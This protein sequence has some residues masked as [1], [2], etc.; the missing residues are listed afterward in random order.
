MSSTEILSQF[1]RN[2]L[3]GE[4]VPDDLKILL[5]HRDELAE[6]TGIRLEW[7]EGWAPWLDTSHLSEADRR[8][9]DTMA[10]IR[11][12]EEVCGHIAFVAAAEDEEITSATMR[13]R[14]G[15]GV[16]DSLLVFFE[17]R[18]PVPLVHRLQ[19][20]RGHIGKSLRLR[21]IQNAPRVAPIPRDIDRLG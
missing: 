4:S 17:Q 3:D 5:P 20:R 14:P 12:I 6:R 10:N 18:R 11:A 9:P 7:A 19:L 2:R 1:S 21:G 8:I 15:V 13:A 16:A